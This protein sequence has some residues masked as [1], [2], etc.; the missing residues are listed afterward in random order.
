MTRDE[1]LQRMVDTEPQDG[2]WRPIERYADL[3]AELE[4]MLSDREMAVLVE[5]GARLVRS[6]YPHLFR[7]TQ[8]VAP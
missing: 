6:S 8:G 5:V 4:R 7:R 3:L 1:V 2:A